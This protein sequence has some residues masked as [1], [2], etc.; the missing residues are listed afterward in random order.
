VRCG[1]REFAGSGDGSRGWVCG[2]GSFLRRL[3]R[4]FGFGA[5]ALLVAAIVELLVGGL[6]LH[7]HLIMS[8]IGGHFLAFR[9]IGGFTSGMPKAGRCKV[10]A[11]YAVKISR[12]R[13]FLR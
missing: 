1:L 7:D 13:P 8:Q 3:P 6:F 4:G 9:R 12:P 2:R 11:S 5:F 10:A